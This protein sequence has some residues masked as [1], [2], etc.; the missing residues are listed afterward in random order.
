VNTKIKLMNDAPVETAKMLDQVFCSDDPFVFIEE[1]TA[2]ID[3]AL[4]EA[5]EILATIP[6]EDHG[7]NTWS[8]DNGSE[9]CEG[10]K[11]HL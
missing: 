9:K 2:E 8:Y 4:N 3:M 5:S 10:D 6:P 7:G 11:C 1:N